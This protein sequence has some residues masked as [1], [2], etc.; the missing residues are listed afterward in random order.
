MSKANVP[1][2]QVVYVTP[3]SAAAAAAAS[4]TA[5][6][7]SNKS[8]SHTVGI[9]VGVVV[10]VIGAF[11]IAGAIFLFMRRNKRRELEE[12]HKRQVAQ[13]AFLNNGKPGSSGGDSLPDSRLDPAVL[14][15][16]R[17]SDGSIMDNQD[18]SRRILQVS[19]PHH[20]PLPL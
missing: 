10:G 6:T 1:T 8:H 3:S 16:R 11:A 4:S 9:A 18:Y 13:S 12:E 20:H 15:E 2:G 14:R 17:L 19:F 5:P 7:V